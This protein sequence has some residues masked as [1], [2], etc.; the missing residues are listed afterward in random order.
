MLARI[1]LIGILS[2][3][4]LKITFAQSTYEKQPSLLGVHFTLQDFV[5]KKWAGPFS[6]MTSGV[7]ISYLKGVSRRVDIGMYGGAAFPDSL[8]VPGLSSSNATML[9]LGLSARVR[10]FPYPRTFQPFVFSAVEGAVMKN[11][12]SSFFTPGLG[13]QLSKGQVSFIVQTG[14]GWEMSGNMGNK[15]FYSAGIA[16]LI[17]PSKGRQKNTKTAPLSIADIA[18]VAPVVDRDK[19]GVPDSLDKCPDQPGLASFSGC[20]DSDGDG[21]PDADDQCPNVAGIASMNGCP[22]K[23]SDGDGIPDVRDQCPDVMGFAETNGCP[24]KLPAAD[25]ILAA[26]AAEIYFETAKYTLLPASYPALQRVDSLLNAMPWITL[27]I[28]GHTDNQG[29]DKINLELS[30]N[31]ADAVKRYLINK[32]HHESQLTATGYGSSQPVD[33]NDTSRG[34]QRNRRVVMRIRE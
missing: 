17:R 8:E 12:F 4:I 11:N 20:P 27:I 34:R 31:R 1:F 2:V 30:R 25:S 6:S 28:E 10:A 26:A 19:D 24:V 5:S 13:L 14:Y 32:G 18:T 7:S 21:I 16:G 9:Q 22:L 3:G 23:D 15:F 33:T 29:N